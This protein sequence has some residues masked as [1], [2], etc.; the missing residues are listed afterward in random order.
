MRQ[1]LGGLSD[2]KTPQKTKVR[3]M[4][5]TGGLNYL[6]LYMLTKEKDR[7]EQEKYIVEK[8]KKNVEE[9]LESIT[10]QLSE[11]GVPETNPD[12]SRKGKE[13]V[14]KKRPRKDFKVMQIDY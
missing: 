13:T 6:D 14:E 9:N 5:R 7:L 2:I 4:P 10:E 8:R 12:K 1:K 3:S 11:A